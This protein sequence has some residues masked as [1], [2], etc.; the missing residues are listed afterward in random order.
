MKVILGFATG[1]RSLIKA[2]PSL[3]VIFCLKMR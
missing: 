3:K 1:L 2:S